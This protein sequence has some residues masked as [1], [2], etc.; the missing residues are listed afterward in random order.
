MATPT[1]HDRHT[2]VLDA[3]STLAISDLVALWDLVAGGDADAITAALV[4][5]APGLV[6]QWGEM[7]AV[8]AADF[9]DAVREHYN[10]G[11]SFAAAPAGPAPA[12][13]VEAMVRWAVGPL[14]QAESDE[15]AALKRLATGLDRLVR[16][17]DRDTVAGNATL[18]K[19]AAGWRRVARPGACAWCAMLATR[20]DYSSKDAAGAV[21]GGGRVRGKRPA[22]SRYHDHCRCFP[23]PVYVGWEPGPQEQLWAEA[24]KKA[25]VAG[26]PKATLANMRQILN[27]S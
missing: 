9:F 3:I 12:G 13:Q 27:T 17:A 19:K 22:G 5:L 6:D 16:Q 14:Y 4:E 10:P 25:A 18:D 24:Y 7:A 1:L 8:E 23:E 11:G 15:D 2:R 21:G 20:D 26:D